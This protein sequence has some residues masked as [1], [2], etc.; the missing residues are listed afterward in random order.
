MSGTINMP[1]RARTCVGLL[2]G[3]HVLQRVRVEAQVHAHGHAHAAEVEGVRAQHVLQPQQ[4]HVRAQR[5]LAHA[6]RVEV[7]LVLHYLR[8]VLLN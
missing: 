4:P 7:E 5:H 1:T 2:R 8:E 3:R 6:V